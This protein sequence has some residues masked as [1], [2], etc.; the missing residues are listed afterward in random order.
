MEIIEIK[1]YKE[2]RFETAIAL[3]NFDGVHK[4]HCDLIK[5]MI[6][7]A[8]EKKL[9]SGLLVFDNHT[10]TVLTGEGPKTITSL[11]QKFNIFQELG[12]E[13]IYRMKFDLE[14][15]KLLPEEFVRDI[16]VEKLNVK[17]V[18]VGFDYRFG[19]KAAGNADLLKQFGEKYN[20]NVIIL[21]PIYIN[22][23]LVSS[24][25]IRELLQEGK[26]EEAND[27]LGRNY[28][29]KGKV[30]GGKKLGNT[31]GWPTANIEPTDNYVIPKHGVYSTSTIIDREVYLSATSVGKNPTFKDEGLKIETHI[32][33]FNKDIYGK[34]I[35]LQFKHYIRNEI[36][37]NNVEDLKQKVLEDI[38]IAKGGH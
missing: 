26:I 15:M 14:I 11:E 35:E 38:T 24:T 17:S 10:K 8:N 23:E 16:L 21:E 29:I 4:G 36:K 6:K 25:R 19:H 28:A 30:V 5:C 12:V 13:L 18:V 1:E 9:K 3:G 31:L 22:G 27:L 7:D 32:I 33:D 2:T 37:F 34:E 20:F